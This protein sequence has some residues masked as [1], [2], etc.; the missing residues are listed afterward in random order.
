MGNN[1]EAV[2][3]LANTSYLIS[4]T[5]QFLSAPSILYIHVFAK[6]CYSHDTCVCSSLF[7]CNQYWYSS[8]CVPVPGPDGELIFLFLIVPR[9]S[10]EAFLHLNTEI[11]RSISTRYSTYRGAYEAFSL[12]KLLSEAFLL[13]KV[14][15]NLI[16]ASRQ[17][18]A[19]RLG[20][21][22]IPLEFRP[23]C[24]SGDS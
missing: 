17:I 14:L 15:T 20:S 24:K 19:T 16:S 7:T 22:H 1:S 18:L 4:H 6:C 3:L 12:I 2:S 9:I 11:I 21:R 5:Y 23:S 13:L 8:P 10:E